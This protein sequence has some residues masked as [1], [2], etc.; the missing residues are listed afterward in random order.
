VAPFVV[1]MLIFNL[2]RRYGIGFKLAFI[3]GIA[4]VL[5][6][7]AWPL[8][9]LIGL[10]EKCDNTSS[11]NS[12]FEKLGPV[13]ALLIDGPG[14]WWLDGKIDVER[15]EWGKVEKFWRREAT[16]VDKRRGNR[17]PRLFTEAELR[18]KYK[19]TLRGPQGGDFLHRYQTTASIKIEDRTT[20]AIVASVQEPA[21]GGGLAGCYIGAL[22]SLNPLNTNSRYLSCGYAS[23]GFGI[24]RGNSKE[25]YQL[26]R[27]ADQK[28]IEK[29]FIPFNEELS[30][31]GRLRGLPS[32]LDNK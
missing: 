2:L 16:Q 27:S 3:G 31:R 23:K 24:Y 19:V 7:L 13:D 9:G 18:S 30:G 15:P 25:R 26:Y 11:V 1:A 4:P 20:G 5:L 6:L 21:W 28:L 29:V 22:T 8:S 14:M 12:G 10:R 32:T 17:S